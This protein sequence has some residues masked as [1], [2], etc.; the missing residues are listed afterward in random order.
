MGGSIGLDPCTEPDNPTRAERFYALPT[1]GLAQPWDAPTIY[2]NPPYG[3]AARPWAR[4]CL[5]IGQARRS[6]VALLLPAYTDTEIGQALIA[7]ADAVV[8]IAGRLDFGTVRPDGKPWRAH[9]G[10]MLV[11][12]GLDVGDELGVTMRATAPRSTLALV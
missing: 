5:E 6:S 10:S 1:D 3:D 4:R 12:W 2:C 11:T 7:G 8:F 9:F